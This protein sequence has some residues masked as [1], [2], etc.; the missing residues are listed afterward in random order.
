METASHWSPSHT[1]NT[2]CHPLEPHLPWLL[3]LHVYNKHR[4][5]E[6]KLHSMQ[7]YTPEVVSVASGFTEAG[8][9]SCSGLGLL[10]VLSDCG[11]FSNTFEG[12]F[13]MCSSLSEVIG[14]HF[15]KKR[16]NYSSVANWMQFKCTVLLWA[17]E[18][19]W[20]V[21]VGCHNKT[22]GYIGTYKSICLPLYL[23]G[24]KY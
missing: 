24:Q 13:F 18:V 11:C 21:S 12:A 3:W 10:S 2:S 14:V 15:W 8:G 16:S 20:K 4:I 23:R 17:L 5:L 1:Y 19:T 22:L 7:V 6:H 9:S